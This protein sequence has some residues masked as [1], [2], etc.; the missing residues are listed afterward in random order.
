M[1]RHEYTLAGLL[2]ITLLASSGLIVHTLHKAAAQ[3]VEPPAEA[4]DYRPDISK[5]PDD[6]ALWD[7]I[8]H[9]MYAEDT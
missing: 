5:C 8:R 6:V 3:P 1:R 7:C 4:R 9:A 2:L